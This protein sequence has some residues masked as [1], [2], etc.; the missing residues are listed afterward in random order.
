MRK[1]CWNRKEKWRGCFKK[2]LK[3]LVTS[4][5]KSNLFLE[6]HMNLVTTFSWFVS[7]LLCPGWTCLIVKNI[8]PQ[9]WKI[10][11]SIEKI[12]DL[13]KNYARKSFYALCLRV[14]TR[15]LTRNYADHCVYTRHITPNYAI[16]NA[17]RNY[18]LHI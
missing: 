6:T 17:T 12:P 1:H 16:E 9:L 4:P 10:C 13:K 5:P 11:D 14:I 2:W 8:L 18:A 3:F 15:T 7:G